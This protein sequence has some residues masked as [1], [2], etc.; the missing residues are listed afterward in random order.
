MQDVHPHPLFAYG[1]LMKDLF[2]YQIY[3]KGKVVG[4]PIKARIKGELYHL[5]E[6]GYPALLSG[7]DWVYGEVFELKD[8]QTTLKKL[9]KLE[10]Y[11]GNQASGNEYERE[12]VKVNIYNSVTEL[13]DGELDV[14]C[15]LYRLDND[16]EFTQ[17][18]IYLPDRKSVV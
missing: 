15:Y 3:L 12:L 2:N 16:S 9:D 4:T 14:Y 18:S 10:G 5:T 7:N 6:K 8:F 1:S 17:K 13:Y 11:S